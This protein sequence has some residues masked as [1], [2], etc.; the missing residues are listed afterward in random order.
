MTALVYRYRMP[1]DECPIP[2]PPA[3][4]RCLYNTLRGCAIYQWLP[5]VCSTVCISCAS[6]HSARQRRMPLDGRTEQY[7]PSIP[8]RGS[9][10]HGSAPGASSRAS[11]TLL[12]RSRHTWPCSQDADLQRSCTWR[13]GEALSALFVHTSSSTSH[14]R[15]SASPRIII[16]VKRRRLFSPFTSLLSCT[17]QYGIMHVDRRL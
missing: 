8:R 4:T 9:W 10:G 17:H 2:A 16:R 5:P 11:S 12:S 1:D 14:I 13:R 6:A 7:P 15:P 3:K